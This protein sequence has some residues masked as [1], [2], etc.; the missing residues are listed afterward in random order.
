M[1]D[2]DA[3]VRIYINSTETHEPI[4]CIE[5]TLSNGKTVYQP[6]VGWTTAVISGLGLTAA[7]ITSGLGH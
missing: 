4:T 7:A 2:L 1:P 3:T 6:G 5:A